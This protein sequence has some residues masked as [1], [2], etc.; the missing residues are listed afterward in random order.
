MKR[1]FSNFG[2]S[3]ILISFVMI[4]I[5]TFSALSLVT[6]NSDYK[7]SQKTADETRDY[8]QAEAAA[9]RTLAE[10]DQI[11]NQAYD[12]TADQNLFFEKASQTLHSYQ[13]EHLSV[14]LTEKEGT[15]T[16]TFEIPIRKD[17]RLEVSLDI[18]YPPDSG[19]VF[20]QLTGWQTLTG[21]KQT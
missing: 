12:T 1:S 19:G 21:G 16:V 13:E 9:Y 15:P 20:Y 2:F 7:L 8:Y 11:L 3:T 18:C 10:I 4:C 5:V 6:A 14:C 17:Q